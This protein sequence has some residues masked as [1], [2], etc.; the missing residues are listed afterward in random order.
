MKSAFSR[1]VAVLGA[2]LALV[3][4]GSDTDSSGPSA[5]AYRIE[6]PSTAAAVAS[7]T[8][9]VFVFDATD[10]SSKGTDCLTLVIKRKS[11]AALPGALAQSVPAAPCELLSGSK[12]GISGVTYGS[13][14]FLAVTQRGDDDFFLGCSLA[15]VSDGGPP[16]E[17]P[18]APAGP[19]V[20]VP[21]TDC[22]ELSE[23]CSGGC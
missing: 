2:C 13:R 6:F 8:V 15:E 23:K 9:Q 4:C 17:I 14:S 7:E 3:G 12:G 1:L 20:S 21:D 16:V 11:K 18:L 5:A 19:T 22:T 10:A